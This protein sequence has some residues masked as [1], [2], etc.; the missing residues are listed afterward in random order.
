MAHP[1]RYDPDDDYLG[2]LREICLALPDAKEKVSHGRP[3]F[4]TQKIFAVFGGLV[5]GDHSSDQFGQSVLILPDRD[6]RLALLQDERFFD[7]AYYGPS[8][9][10]GFDFRRSATDGGVDWGEVSELVED[11]YRNT[12]SVTRVRRLDAERG[13]SD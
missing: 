11:S 10:V 9:W 7:P 4:F 13:T 3:V 12:A 5:K 6:E 2:Q 1:T 8:G